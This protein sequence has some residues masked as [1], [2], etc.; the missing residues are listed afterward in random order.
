VALLYVLS[1]GVDLVLSW[2]TIA[3]G[4]RSASDDAVPGAAPLAL[5]PAAA[6]DG[7]LELRDGLLGSGAAL[8]NLVAAAGL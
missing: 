5:P 6:A 4:E 3:V 7:D 1:A 8:C 2:V